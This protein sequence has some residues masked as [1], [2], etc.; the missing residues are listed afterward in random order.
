M[1]Y[2]RNFMLRYLT[3]I[4]GKNK[5]EYDNMTAP[6]AYQ[7]FFTPQKYSQVMID[8]LD[9]L[10]PKKVIDLAMGEGSLLIESKQK[11]PDSSYYGNDIDITCCKSLPKEHTDI[12][13][14]H[15]DIFMNSSIDKLIHK[16]GKVDLCLGN[17]P[18]HKIKQTP[19]IKK[20]L[21]KFQ[22][23]TVYKSEFIPSEV[24]FML[25]SFKIIN[26]NGTLA[27]ILPDGFFTNGYLKKFRQFI[28]ENYHVQKVIELP[29]N[30]FKETKAKTHILILK[31]VK[32]AYQKINLS[33]HEGDSIEI[34]TSEAIERMDYSYYK[35]KKQIN[36]TKCLSD[37]NI[38][39][40]RGIPRYRLKEFNNNYILHTTSFKK[41]YQFKSPLRTH[42]KLHEF[43]NRIAQKN[44]III[45]RVGSSILGRV[46]IVENGYFIATD[47]IFV[48]RAKSNKDRQNI[49]NTLRSEFGQKWIASISKGVG[50]R[51][52][53]L[54]DIWSMPIIQ[55]ICV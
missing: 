47:C 51:H 9:I 55:D 41:T 45:P 35:N 54:S 31:N 10:E 19:N 33:Y 29:E 15:N 39:I 25:Q 42:K 44:D 50:A 8:S 22:L 12:N 48:I 13:C 38:D 53:T 18:F 52:I 30:I 3:K 20:I 7:Q 27:F 28:L 32:L 4:N 36:N 46:G 17:P 21:K 6:Q 2:R 16:I 24:P 5:G 40:F 11:W 43:T 49:E 23:D 34:S 37:L 1:S 26:E 14:F